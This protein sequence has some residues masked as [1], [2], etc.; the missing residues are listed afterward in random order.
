MPNKTTVDH[1][2][3][4]L[5]NAPTDVFV[6]ILG[7]N[8]NGDS[9]KRI[10]VIYNGNKTAQELRI[11]GD[12]TLVANDKRAGTETLGTMTDQV[13]VEPCSLVVAHSE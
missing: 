1:F 7:N 2:L 10:L 11:P 13:R 6:Y 12:W 3:H 5:A 8:A 9:W 4:F